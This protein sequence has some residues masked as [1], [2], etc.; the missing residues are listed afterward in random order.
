[1]KFFALIVGF[2]AMIV[3]VF[4]TQGQRNMEKLKELKQQ[5]VNVLV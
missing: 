5:K 1:M 4:A 2:L 3:V